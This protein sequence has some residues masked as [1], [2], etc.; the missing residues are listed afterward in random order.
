MKKSSYWI[1]GIF[2]IFCLF[3]CKKTD[4][5]SAEIDHTSQETE[6]PLVTVWGWSEDGKVAVSTLLDDGGRGGLATGVFIFNTVNDKVLWENEIN[7]YDFDYDKAAY[8][9]AY[10]EFIDN[11]QRTCRQQY[12]IEIKKQNFYEDG[13]PSPII[14]RKSKDDKKYIYFIDIDVVP[15]NSDSNTPF[16]DT[17]E[18]YS[19]RV[20]ADNG[21][22]K[23]IY[24]RKR[25]NNDDPLYFETIDL[26]GCS[27]S[28]DGEKV[29]IIIKGE[30]S[31]MDGGY[32]F[33]FTGCNLM[34][35]F[36]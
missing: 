8:N 29:L 15:L 14:Y 25:K 20:L 28:P 34:T 36:E 23:T 24:S 6:Y 17:M 9:K 11:F 18:S 12:N 5:L 4:K 10:T 13:N 16:Y 31:Y 3:N 30:F 1:I 2:C 22:K 33:I 35:G 19:V 26:Y 21:K 27:Y 7:S 32:S